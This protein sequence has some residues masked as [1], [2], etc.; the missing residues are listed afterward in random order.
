M[1]K[2][3]VFLIVSVIITSMCGCSKSASEQVSD[4]DGSKKLYYLDADKTH[5]ESENYTPLGTTQE[6]L[7]EEYIASFDINPVS[8]S[9]QKAKPSGVVIKSYAFGADGQLV[10]YFN[11]RYS[12]VS[13][14]SEI[15]MRAVI[16]RTLCQ[17]EG[18]KYIEFYVNDL[19]LSVY[20]TPVGLMAAT[21]F[22]DN[23]GAA[24]TTTQYTNLTIYYSNMSGTALIETVIEVEFDGDMTKEQLVMQ[25]LI[26]GPDA[27]Y[28]GVM[29]AT[30]PEGTIVNSV[31]TK[32]GICYVDF[33]STF[34]NGIDG[35]SERVIVYSVVNSLIEIAN[36]N[37]VQI[38]VNGEIRKLYKTL[39]MTEFMERNLQIIEG[40]Y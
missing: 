15:L 17:V 14:I 20:G 1:R 19:P 37:R 21:D 13:G 7:I 22:I 40:T 3:I 33:N 6:E 31:V 8:K 32:D 23:A 36:A 9:L 27:V 12:S 24:S 4:T 26:N 18:V 30:L 29:K 39:E 28:D 11:E 5:I 2:L 38:T 35:I 16:V 10:L 25:Q 34:L